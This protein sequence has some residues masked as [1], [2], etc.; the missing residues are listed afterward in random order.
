VAETV[1]VVDDDPDIRTFVDIALSLAG[2]ETADAADGEEALERALETNPSIIVMDVMMPRM[3]GFEAV[4]QLRADGRLSHIPV[5]LLTAKSQTP[6]K[7]AGFDAGADDYLTKPFDPNELVAR[8]KATLRRA[9]DMRTI[10]PLT[11]LPGNTAID[12][13]IARRVDS[14]GPFAVLYAD[15]NNFKAF[16]DHYGFARG[17]DVINKAASTIVDAAREVGGP[18]TFVGHIGGDDFVVVTAVELWTTLADTICRRFDEVAPT[19]YDES[20]QLAGHVEVEDRQGVMRTYPL[21]AISIGVATTELRD[22]GHPSEVVAVATEMKSYA[23]SLVADGGSNFAA[24]RR[25]ED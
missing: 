11:G 12:K 25:A 3:D 21:V 23:K 16:N 19:L 13:E 2:Y 18:E 7:V 17:D 20:D 9:E 8:V 22:F 24:D 6:D 4:R 5:I 15:L 14:K 1:L 10:Q